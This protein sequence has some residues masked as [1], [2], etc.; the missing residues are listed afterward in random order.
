MIH[1]WLIN[2]ITSIII[3]HSYKCQPFFVS[4]RACLRHKHSYVTYD[5]L[6]SF[7]VK[8][9]K[10]SHLVYRRE[11]GIFIYKKHDTIGQQLL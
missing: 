9:R 1:K 6:T 7:S 10:R 5:N 11:G 4:L 8:Q 3:L 2:K